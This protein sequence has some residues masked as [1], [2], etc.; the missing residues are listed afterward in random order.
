MQ[1][2]C[3]SVH[4]SSHIL[5]ARHVLAVTVATC[6]PINCVRMYTCYSEIINVDAYHYGVCKCSECMQNVSI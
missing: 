5:T 3:A 6:M 1:T 4:K 2:R